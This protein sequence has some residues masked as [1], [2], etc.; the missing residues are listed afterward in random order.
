MPAVDEAKSFIMTF[1]ERRGATKENPVNPRN[2]SSSN[3]WRDQEKE[4]GSI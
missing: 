2:Q 4:R 3:S 1:A